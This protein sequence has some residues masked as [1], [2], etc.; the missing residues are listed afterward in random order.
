MKIYFV[1]HGESEHNALNL[2][3]G[4]DVGLSEKG[5]RQ[6]EILADRISRISIDI[7]FSSPYKRAKQTTEIISRTTNKEINYTELLKERKRPTEI[8]GKSATDTEVLK[9]IELID[10]HSGDH[11]WRYSDEESFAEFE[12]RA[13]EFLN[14]LSGL[15][16]ENILV[17]AHGGPIKMIIAL[18]MQGEQLTPEMFY[19]FDDLFS[20][21]NTGITLCE[22]KETNQWRVRA[23]NDHSH[24]G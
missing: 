16:Y 17:V 23:W 15:E 22:K 21:S 13:V 11:K 19:R 10:S 3:Q 8:E 24:L 4:G 9:I 5:L 1:R 14:F 12:Y 6:A 20:L 2:H 18:M 7:I